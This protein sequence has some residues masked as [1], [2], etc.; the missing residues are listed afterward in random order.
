MVPA[1]RRGC[2]S[3]GA[4]LA[5]LSPQ[6]ADIRVK[7]STAAS[8]EGIFNIVLT[9]VRWSMVGRTKLPSMIS[10]RSITNSGMASTPRFQAAWK[11]QP[12]VK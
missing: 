4:G 11:R 2:A 5:A 12:A 1:G 9:L 8:I 3:A 6:V 7:A 10:R